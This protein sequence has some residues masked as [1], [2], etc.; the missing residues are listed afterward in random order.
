M[1]E[2]DVMTTLKATLGAALLAMLTA[3]PVAAQQHGTPQ[4]PHHPDA[5]AAA[6]GAADR[7][8]PGG[9]MPMMDM[10]RQMMGD[11]GGVGMGMMQGM[12]ADSKERAAMLEMRGEM[13][14]AMGDV[15]MK[16]A[17]RMNGPAGRK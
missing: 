17:R 7:G 15:M 3:A 8:M 9:A 2:E 16:H 12:P 14:K 10:C 1:K 13:M 11:G 5:K 6:P 4:Q